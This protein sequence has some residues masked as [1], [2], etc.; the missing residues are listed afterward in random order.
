MRTVMTIPKN[1]ADGDDLIVISKKR[2]EQL[3][4]HLR[5]VSD[6]LGKISRGEKE[7]REGKT[8]ITTKSLK[9]LYR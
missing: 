8:R 5:E 7:L 6:A 4:K 1:L 9:E 2:Y 3:Q